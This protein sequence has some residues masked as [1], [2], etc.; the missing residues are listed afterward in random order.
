MNTHVQN[1]SRDLDFNEAWA[2][3]SLR[4]RDRIRATADLARA[5]YFVDLLARTQVAMAAQTVAVKAGAIEA[6]SSWFSPC[7]D[8]TFS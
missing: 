6:I 1:A 4:E 8:R 5:E 7:K 3:I 2:Y